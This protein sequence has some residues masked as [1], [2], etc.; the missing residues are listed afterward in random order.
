MEDTGAK[1]TFLTKEDPWTISGT[2]YAAMAATRPVCVAL[3]MQHLLNG[4]R[5]IETTADWVPNR[6]VVYV[7]DMQARS[8]SFANHVYAHLHGERSGKSKAF[9]AAR[10]GGPDADDEVTVMSPFEK[11]TTRVLDDYEKWCGKVGAFSPSVYGEVNRLHE[12]KDQMISGRNNP[13]LEVYEVTYQVRKPDFHAYRNKV[14]P[15]TMLPNYNRPRFD[16]REAH[17]EKEGCGKTRWLVVEGIQMHE[18]KCPVCTQMCAHGMMACLN[19]GIFLHG[20]CHDRE[21]FIQGPHQ[22]QLR[23][24]NVGNTLLRS[25]PAKMPF[26]T[27]RNSCGSCASMGHEM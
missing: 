26:L 22:K 9:Y 20:C 5:L 3:G 6:F 21:P 25:K 13:D 10:T 8:Y 18:E 23:V 17:P 27:L 1:Y 16:W 2:D 24:T 7:Y 19:C 4:H 12:V 14:S 15:E 11:Y